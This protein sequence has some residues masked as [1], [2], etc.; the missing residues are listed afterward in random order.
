MQ[1]TYIPYIEKPQGYGEGVLR[2]GQPLPIQES[3]YCLCF[4]SCFNDQVMDGRF[5]LARGALKSKKEEE[6]EETEEVNNTKGLGS[7]IN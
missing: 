6:E 7:A 1:G 3:V 5:D 4:M 2:I